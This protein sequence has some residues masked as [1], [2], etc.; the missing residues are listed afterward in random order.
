MVVVV[1]VL[2]AVVAVLLGLGVDDFSGVEGVGISGFGN[3][4]GLETI[5]NDSVKAAA[6][7]IIAIQYVNVF[8][9]FPRP[10][11]YLLLLMAVK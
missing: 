11:L 7:S 5:R 10:N 4:V 9:V 8:V 3:D 6:T 2:V 1:V